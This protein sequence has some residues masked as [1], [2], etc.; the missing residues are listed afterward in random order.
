MSEFRKPTEYRF[1]LPDGSFRYEIATCMK[2]VWAFYKMH[3]ARSCAAI[4]LNAEPD[5]FPSGIQEA[6]AG[7]EDNAP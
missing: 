4:P 2:D 6:M 7:I 1:T 3:K 5:P